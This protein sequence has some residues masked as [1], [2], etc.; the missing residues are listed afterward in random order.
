MVFEIDWLIE[1]IKMVFIFMDVLF[2]L[3]NLQNMYE[4]VFL[5]YKD[6]YWEYVYNK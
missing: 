4:F 2:S 5:L 3:K 6:K 1:G